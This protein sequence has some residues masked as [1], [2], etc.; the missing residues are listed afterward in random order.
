MIGTSE[1]T[2]TDKKRDRRKK[3]SRQSNEAHERE[4]AQKLIDKL[5]VSQSVVMLYYYIS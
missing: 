1:K 4:K 5:K 2:S 3:K